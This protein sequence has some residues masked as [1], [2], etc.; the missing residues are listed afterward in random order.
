[1]SAL[2]RATGADGRPLFLL[3]GGLYLE[4]RLG[5][6]A[7]ATKDVDTLFRGEVEAMAE[8]LDAALADPWGPLAFQRTEIEQ[9]TADRQVRPCRFDVVLTIRG[10]TWRR[11]QVEVA[12]PEGRIGEA[13]EAVASPP[14]GYFGL[15]GA[16]ELATITMAYQVAQKIH[17]CT[18][19]HTSERPNSRVRDIADLVLVRRHLYE[20]ATAWGPVTA[21]CTDVFRAR[22]VEA[23]AL[24][25][26]QRPW[27]P[28]VQTNELWVAGWPRLA[29][30]LDLSLSLDQAVAEVNEWIEGLSTTAG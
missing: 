14:L 12:Y 5:L 27:P 2:Q 13:A 4:H 16:P 6:A 1:M 20:D 7:R 11:I 8:E 23:A 10:V 29:K 18:D 17:A 25:L 15:A 30:E 21:A 19:P 26:Q 28:A 3:K 9:I 24:G 22:G